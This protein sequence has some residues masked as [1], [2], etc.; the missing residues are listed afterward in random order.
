M[1]TLIT[2]SKHSFGYVLTLQDTGK[3]PF[4]SVL[5]SDHPD[6]AA[7]AVIHAWEN[8][9]INPEGIKIDVPPEV[10]SAIRARGS[11]PWAP[12]A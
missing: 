9:A 5:Q 1:P 2:V 4:S 11:L 3:R 10:A 12:P 8:N 7:I 6:I